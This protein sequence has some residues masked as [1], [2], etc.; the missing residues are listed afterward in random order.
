M[1]PFLSMAINRLGVPRARL[2]ETLE[3]YREV[4]GM[5]VLEGAVVGFGAPVF[6]SQGSVALEVIPSDGPSLSS[7]AV[8]GY[9][10]I[11]LGLPDVNAAVG[12][13][14]E[15]G[16]DVKPGS[17]FLDVGFLTHLK[18]PIGYTIELLQDTFEANFRA[19]APSTR[20][21]A[22]ELPK[23]GQVTL[24][25]FDID[26]SLA[27]YRDVLG[28]SLLCSYPVGDYGF[29]LYFLAFTQETPPDCRDPS[30]IENREW[31]YSRPYTTLEL[32]V[33]QAH[34]G[35]AYTVPAVGAPAWQGLVFGVRSLDMAKEHLA[36][37]GIST[38][39]APQHGHLEV[40]DP[41]GYC[42]W[43]RPACMSY[44]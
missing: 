38:S 14:Q 16:V 6:D 7:D 44:L 17:Q 4:L 22:C 31:T 15:R 30:A 27:F 2:E 40:R 36:K 42:I 28:M 34:H 26:R 21:L 18:D 41:D 25:V 39:P 23:V 24:R 11:G 3:F 37:R 8:C 12:R 29:S 9:W 43:L 35:G 20:P 1:T 32:Q 5:N 10:K 19:P 13:L 33:K